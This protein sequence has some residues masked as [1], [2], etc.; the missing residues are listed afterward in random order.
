MSSSAFARIRAE[1]LEL[2]VRVP[3][4]KV[5]THLAIAEVLDLAARQVAFLLMTLKGPDAETVPWHRAVSASGALG[6]HQKVA[7][8]R[9]RL[10]AEGIA[11]EDDVVDLARHFVA[12]GR[13]PETT[14]PHPARFGS[15]STKA[16]RRTKGS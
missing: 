12:P 8:Q 10:E 11:F 1:V 15:A 16:P 14:R 6:R 7:T 2:I 13:A 5:A 3:E 9:R 4:G